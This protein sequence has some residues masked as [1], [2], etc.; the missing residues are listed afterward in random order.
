VAKKYAMLRLLTEK[1]AHH[2]AVR[3]LKE[4]EGAVFLTFLSKAC[5]PVT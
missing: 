4:K 1:T 5:P 3:K 2:T